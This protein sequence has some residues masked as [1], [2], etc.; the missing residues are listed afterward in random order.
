MKMVYIAA[1][2]SLTAGLGL[3]LPQAS[4]EFVIVHHLKL[5]DLVIV[6]LGFRDQRSSILC[7]ATKLGITCVVMGT[8]TKQRSTADQYGALFF[9]TGDMDTQK[10]LEMFWF[11]GFHEA[12]KEAFNFSGALHRHAA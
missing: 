11:M 9:D 8:G 1:S 7:E 12:V 2:E 3:L 6:D 10:F 5:A 4:Y